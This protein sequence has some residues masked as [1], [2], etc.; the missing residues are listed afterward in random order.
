MSRCFTPVAILVL[1]EDVESLAAG[2]VFAIDKRG[3]WFLQQPYLT[4]TLSIEE[5]KA[6][7]L[8]PSRLFRDHWRFHHGNDSAA[9]PAFAALR[10]AKYTVVKGALPA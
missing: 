10:R 9:A 2:S 1:D 3:D 5:R 6:L 4:A 8:W 7:P